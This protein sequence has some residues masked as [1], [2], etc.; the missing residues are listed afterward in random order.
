MDFTVCISAWRL[1][2]VRSDILD[3]IDAVV[4]ELM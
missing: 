1:F 4:L 2:S 3:N